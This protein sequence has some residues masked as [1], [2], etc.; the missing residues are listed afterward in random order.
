MADRN[1]LAIASLI[2][3]G[4]LQVDRT[5]R[6]AGC[7]AAGAVSP[8]TA[9]AP[10]PTLARC[11][12]PRR[13]DDEAPVPVDSVRD[14]RPVRYGA[15]IAAAPRRSSGPSGRRGPPRPRASRRAA[16]RSAVR[17]PAGPPRAGARRLR[18]R[19][20]ASRLCPAAPPGSALSWTAT[21]SPIPSTAQLS[22]PAPT[23]ASIRIPASFARPSPRSSTMSFGH[24]T[25][26]RG[27]TRN[28]APRRA[29]R[30]PR[31]RRTAATGA[32]RVAGQGRPA[33]SCRAGPTTAVPGALARRSARRR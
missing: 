3:R 1:T 2:G 28:R 19:A 18:C 11:A 16:L 27:G 21:L 14:A 31:L 12:R 23:R 15:G 22:P 4:A 25:R 17:A 33:G 6:A 29:P 5:G 32:G 20:R 24:L 30:R 26:A 9:G 10:R 8:R 7:F 13:A